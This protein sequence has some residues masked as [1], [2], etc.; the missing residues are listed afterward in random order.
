MNQL[1][2]DRIA[3]ATAA[4]ES[5]RGQT[6]ELVTIGSILIDRFSVGGTLM[7]AGNG[8]SAVQAM[9]LAE[10]LT[11]RYRETRAALP[12]L[13]L[14]SDAAAMTCIANDFGWESVFS[15]QVEA[16]VSFV[17]GEEEDTLTSNDVLLVLS[18]SGESANII[19]A[20]ETAN[21]CGV[22]TMGLLGRGGG[23]SLEAC[24]HAVVIDGKDSAAIQ[25][26]HQVAL[27]A[28]CEMVEAWV[29][30]ESAVD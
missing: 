9:H 4:I 2:E 17:E 13:S 18:T 11:A 28:L 19:R 25:D 16:H 7:T 10:E 5:L 21:A 23:A 26:A 22:I 27:H 8:G 24:D 1:V 30:E 20:L 3:H 14:C 6:D 12:A 29:L 15:R